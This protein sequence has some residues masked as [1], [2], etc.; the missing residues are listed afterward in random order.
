MK[1]V[2]MLSEKQAK[3]MNVPMVKLDMGKDY[4]IM[5]LGDPKICL[6]LTGIK[7]LLSHGIKTIDVNNIV[8]KNNKV[9]YRKTK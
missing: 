5:P 4:H 3:E 8:L 1:K 7:M 6:T 2:R 9:S